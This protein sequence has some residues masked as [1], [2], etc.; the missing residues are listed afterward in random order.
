MIT[1]HDARARFGA[2]EPDALSILTERRICMNRPQPDNCPL[3]GWPLCTGERQLFY[4]LAC[5]SRLLFLFIDSYL[6]P[7]LRL[8]AASKEV[9]K[10]KKIL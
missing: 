10:C 9:S 3:Q 7:W 8:L 2:A 4:F 1:W 5:S 6:E